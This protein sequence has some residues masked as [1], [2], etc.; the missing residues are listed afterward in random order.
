ME[1]PFNHL[2][3]IR[4]FENKET[5]LFL[6]MLIFTAGVIG[7]YYLE[8]KAAA[9]YCK[10]YCDAAHNGGYEYESGGACGCYPRATDSSDLDW[11]YLGTVPLE[12]ANSTMHR[13]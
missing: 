3:N 6:V 1:N 11:V 7:A 2:K 4:P 10:M 8:F 5:V 13:S 12:S 9:H